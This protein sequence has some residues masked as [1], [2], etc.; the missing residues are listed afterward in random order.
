MLAISFSVMICMCSN[1]GGCVGTKIA[2]KNVRIAYPYNNGPF[3][4]ERLQLPVTF[5]EAEMEI[6][7]S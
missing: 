5:A 2:V 1:K 6:T 4:V 3:I 7:Q